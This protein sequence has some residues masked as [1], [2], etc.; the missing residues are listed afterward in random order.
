MVRPDT[1]VQFVESARLDRHGGKYPVVSL[2]SSGLVVAVNNSVM[3]NAIW[4]WLG[5]LNIANKSV[6]WMSGRHFDYGVSPSVALSD[7]GVVVE[8]HRS[9][10]NQELWYR[11]GRVDVQRNTIGWRE[12]AK[13]ANGNDPSVAV[14]C[15]NAVVS[16]HTRFENGQWNLYSVVGQITSSSLEIRWWPPRIFGQG[17]KPSIAINDRN[18]VLLVYQSPPT[19]PHCTTWYCVG[20]KTDKAVQWGRNIEYG[21]GWNASASLNV[22]NQ[23]IFVRQS[24]KLGKLLYGVGKINP[25]LKELVEEG[26]SEICRNLTLVEYTRSEKDVRRASFFWHPSVSVNDQGKVVLVYASN[27]ARGR[28]LWHRVGSVDQPDDQG[29]ASP[30]YYYGSDEEEEEEEEENEDGHAFRLT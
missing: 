15:G 18:I 11:S 3:G 25:G 5:R 17:V 6:D 9:Q 10:W 2:S 12:C 8:V 1:D 26:P 13:Y 21:D 29:E 30:P 24:Y 16:M 23:A 27:D 4:Y 28:A 7:G 22:Y 14:G 19:D 20:C